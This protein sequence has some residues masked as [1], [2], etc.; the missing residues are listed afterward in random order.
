MTVRSQQLATDAFV[1]DL[2]VCAGETGPD[3]P[4]GK[5]PLGNFTAYMGT[6]SPP[7]ARGFL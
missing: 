3:P 7:R 6:S 1:T 5:A 4:A 2:R